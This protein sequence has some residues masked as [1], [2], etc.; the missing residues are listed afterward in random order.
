M[1]DRFAIDDVTGR[2]TYASDQGRTW[3]EYDSIL[4]TRAWTF[5]NTGSGAVEHSILD[6]TGA[7]NRTPVSIYNINAPPIELLALRTCLPRP[8]LPVAPVFSAEIPSIFTAPETVAPSVL[9]NLYYQTNMLHAAQGERARLI[10]CSSM[11]LPISSMALPIS[12]RKGWVF[13][14]YG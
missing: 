2:Y 13:G 10:Q 8:R 11:A 9:K 4:D 1:I 3:A 12:I 6:R 7:N 5:A 14:L